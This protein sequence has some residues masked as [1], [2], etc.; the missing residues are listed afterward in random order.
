[1]NT[2]APASHPAS[3][4]PAS[5]PQAAPPKKGVSIISSDIEISGNV[6][7]SGDVHIHGRI[8]GKRPGIHSST[9]EGDCIAL[10]ELLI[11]RLY[12]HGKELLSLADRNRDSVEK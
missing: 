5:K 7:T 4:D 11:P 1:M 10:I 6:E 12:T 3:P 8:D 2:L 9:R